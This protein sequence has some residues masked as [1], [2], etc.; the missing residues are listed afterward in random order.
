MK[1]SKKLIAAFS[2]AAMLVTALS[3]TGCKKEED[4]DNAINGNAI[5]YTNKTSDMYYR[6]FQSLKTKHTSSTAVITINNPE[7]ITDNSHNANSVIGYVFGLEETDA[8][9]GK[10][11]KSYQY[12]E[13]GKLEQSKITWYNFGVAGVRWNKT[14]KKLEWYVSYCTKVPSTIFGWNKSSD[15]EAKLI[16]ELNADGTPKTE[17]VSGATETAIV[18]TKASPYFQAVNYNLVN[19]TVPVRVQVKI[20]ENEDSATKTTAPYIYQVKL[21]NQ[22]GIDIEGATVAKIPVAG[23]N[24]NTQKEIGRYTTV[25][26]KESAN[27]SMTFADTVGN[28]IPVSEDD[29]VDLSK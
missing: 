15:F 23:L 1:I 11:T 5:S 22:Q 2:V 25:Y 8:P 13:D 17:V 9:E 24:A 27:A 6:A 21:Q 10:P 28:P 16:T 4:D 12:K 29:W 26:A 20:V 19:G 18:G 3:V 14:T 7:T